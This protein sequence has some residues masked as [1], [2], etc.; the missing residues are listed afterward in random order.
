M[1]CALACSCCPCFVLSCVLGNIRNTHT[2]CF[3]QVYFHHHFKKD[4]VF[5]IAHL[6]HPSGLIIELFMG[7]H[8]SYTDSSVRSV[9][10]TEY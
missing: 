7:V 8:A 9:L 3:A 10:E 6:A 4:L 2:A 1:V 5:Q